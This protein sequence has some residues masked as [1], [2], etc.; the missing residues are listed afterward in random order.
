MQLKKLSAH[1]T[2][3]ELTVL[4]CLIEFPG[5][6]EMIYNI[7]EDD[8][9]S[10]KTQEL[11]RYLYNAIEAKTNI[12]YLSLPLQFRTDTF[13]YPLIN[14]MPLESSFPYYIEKLKEISNIRKLERISYD[15][16]I[17]VEEK[18]PSDY[19][20]DEIRRGIESLYNKSNKR[21]L[22][23]ETIDKEFYKRMVE[24]SVPYIESGFTDI[25]NII[26]GFMPS[27]FTIIAGAPTIGKTTFALNMVTHI[28]R[29]LQKSILF[30]S[31][32]MSY[33]QLQ[34]KLIAEITEIDSRNIINPRRYLSEEDK[35]KI[36]RAREIIAGYNLYRMGDKETTTGD[37]EDELKILGEVDI[38]F[39]DYLQ[40]LSSKYYIN[41]RYDRITQVSNELKK[42]SRKFDIPIVCIASIN[43]AQHTR[44]DKRPML[45]DL[46]DSGNI[47]YDIDTAL[48]LHRESE[49]R[50]YN[51]N[52][53]T[54]EE[55]YLHEAEVHVAKNRFGEND[56]ITKL[57]YEP[58][59]S[60]FKNI[61]RIKDFNEKPKAYYD[62]EP[63]SS[64][65][66]KPL[67]V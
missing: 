35:I 60:K 57:W 2:E 4:K 23:N 46:R 67:W 8:F 32:E 53:D 42:L 28:C 49:I 30:V 54:S 21:S 41:N 7:A 47:E 39:I 64:S 36:D 29:K 9:Y 58:R 55:Q 50:P 11:F 27:T 38:I 66:N 14:M 52:K 56:I 18:R 25:D 16:K 62:D 24:K 15:I 51:P 63:D 12:D 6:R 65:T 17:M 45:S 10:L 31:L 19:M 43:R 61:S 44:S 5:T 20:K 26:G 33:I 40:L 59:Y 1:D 48:L 22:Q 3:L 34:A 13:F 37:I